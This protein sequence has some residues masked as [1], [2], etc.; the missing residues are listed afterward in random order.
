M[1][2]LRDG[3]SLV[4]ANCTAIPRMRYVRIGVELTAGPP[5]V[6]TATPLTPCRGGII[7]LGF[8]NL[9]RFTES[10]ESIAPSMKRASYFAL[11]DSR[12]TSWPGGGALFL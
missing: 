7:E 2:G 1:N 10:S 8:L 9:P 5:L 3:F 11:E 6:C 12:L 4:F